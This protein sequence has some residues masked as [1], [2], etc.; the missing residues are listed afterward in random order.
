MESNL[1]M[2]SNELTPLAER[3]NYLQALRVTFA[4]ATLLTGMIATRTVPTPMSALFFITSGYISVSGAAESLRR[5]IKG[6]SIGILFGTLLIDGVY[7]S[8]VT[9]VTGGTQSPLRF[10]AFIHIIAVTL[11]ASSRTGLKI[12]LW[13]SLLFFV[14]FYAEAAD[15]ISTSPG[16]LGPKDPRFA[17]LSIFN[18]VALLL[19]ASATAIFSQLNERELRRRRGDLQDLADLASDLESETDTLGVAQKVLDAIGDSF[20]FKRG[21]IIGATSDGMSVWALRGPSETGRLDAGTDAIF[22]EVLELGKSRLIAK[23][24]EGINP[25]LSALL[26]FARNLV[27]V[28]LLADRKRIGL[29]LLENPNAS[30]P[31]IHKRVLDTVERF[32]AHAAL[33][34]RNVE[35]I[36]EVQR[37]AD[38]DSLTGVANR[39]AFG[40]T[41]EKELARS[42]RSGEPV[43]LMMIDIDHFKDYNDAYGHQAGDEVLRLVGKALKA[44]SRQFDTPARYGGEEFVVI[45]PS[46]S[47][48]E[49]FAVAERLRTR[50]CDVEASSPIRAS[51]GVATYPFHAQDVVGLIKAADD[52][53]YES[54]RLGR[55]R[56]SRATDDTDEP[57]RARQIKTPVPGP[58]L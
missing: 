3:I 17:E 12:A 54:K 34:L 42:A 19:V 41:L 49:S 18:V 10:L 57:D 43:T 8:W 32:A 55:D 48:E 4:V 14:A 21:A 46:C 39:R 26:P 22:D 20:G 45:L 35:L 33:S 24:D 36:Q 16:S 50:V 28:P 40:I 47:S 1:T 13:H 27:V 44:A 30:G 56:L 23:L 31:H 29:V 7:I 9:H 5:V 11:L 58:R 38:T 2:R 52:A 53:L 37:T 15:L 6:H 51:A 25:R